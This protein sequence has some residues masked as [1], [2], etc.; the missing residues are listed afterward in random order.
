[1][2]WFSVTDSKKFGRSSSISISYCPIVNPALFIHS[3]ATVITTSMVMCPKA[4]ISS[5][6]EC[7]FV[8]K[9]MKWSDFIESSCY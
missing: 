7:L 9:A 8:T 5:G 3:L 4:M 6:T 1:M 2:A